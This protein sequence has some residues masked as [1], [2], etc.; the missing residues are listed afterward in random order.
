MA[1]SLL[2]QYQA[3]IAEF[4]EMTLNGKFASKGQVARTL[5]TRLEPGS[6]ELFER[7]LQGV[8]QQADQAVTAAADEI[9]Q[10]KALRRRRALKMIQEAW[11]EVHQDFIADHLQAQ[12]IRQ[13]I[14]TEP[15]AML[16]Q[17]LILIDPN[18][19]SQLNRD[20]LQQLAKM[21][22]AR[23][24][25]H[26]EAQ[27][28]DQIGKGV[29]QALQRWSE[30]E[31]DLLGWIYETA[32]GRIG[33]GGAPGTTG[34]WVYWQKRLSPS[35]VKQVLGTLSMQ[36]SLV[37][38]LEAQPKVD[39]ADWV[40]MGL[41]FQWLQRGLIAWFD[42]QAYDPKA[43]P[44]LSIS[45]YLT[46]ATL[47]AECAEGFR[48]ATLLSP[49]TRDCLAEACVLCSLQL[50]RAFTRQPYFPL[51]GG[52][53]AAFSGGYLKQTLDYLDLPLKWVEG[54]QEKARL[55][56][57]I[58]TSQQVLG[59]LPSAI[60]FHRQALELAQQTQDS[61]C[62]IANLNHLSRVALAQQ[63]F[64]EAIDQAQRA[65][66]VSRERGDRQGQ[67][68]ALAN[69]GSS[70]VAQAQ[71]QE[72]S[73]GYDQAMAYLE[74]GLKLA[75]QDGDRPSEALCCL[76]LGL[77]YLNQGQ[78]EVALRYLTQGLNAAKQVGDMARLGQLY[79]Q[80]AEAHYAVGQMEAAVCQA[81]LGM[82]LLNQIQSPQWRQ[83]AGLLSVIQGKQPDHFLQDLQK[84]QADIKAVIGIDGYDAVLDLIEQYRKS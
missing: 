71:Q 60:A 28:L 34:P 47:W 40:E 55:L 52:I 37:E 66:L 21:I 36:Q 30:L 44:R 63:E 2:E 14:R 82:S 18:L 35:W 65:L 7:S 56:T 24:E 61:A 53:F 6:G 45:V 79:T 32:Q 80:L 59:Q 15:E 58:G 27:T 76:H 81:V 46:F 4:V 50:L 8:T 29:T 9:K 19:E 12:I 68:H 75:E 69:L 23:G 41:V 20:Q 72:R 22:L 17:F 25:S 26:P 74:Q 5:K 70:E 64:P 48:Q 13:L 11:S 43:G 31:A 3:L 33:F 57:L 78:A 62:E 77:A 73:Q 84:A 54:V 16:R 10:A 83:A 49:S 1:D 38:W 67:A 51:Y 42:R 39:L